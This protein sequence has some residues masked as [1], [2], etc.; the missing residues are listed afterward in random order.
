MERRRLLVSLGALLGAGSTGAVEPKPRKSS[1][2]SKNSSR[3][4]VS[5]YAA[6]VRAAATTQRDPN[7]GPTQTS[8][9]TRE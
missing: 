6:D 7:S 4:E 5:A 3:S 8:E 9:S 1:G 2:I